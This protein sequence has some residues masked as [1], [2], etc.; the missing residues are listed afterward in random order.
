VRRTDPRQ[1]NHALD[2]AGRAAADIDGIAAAAHGRRALHHSHFEAIT[3]QPASERR[4][5]SVDAILLPLI[6]KAP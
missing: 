5:E 4:A 2:D 3:V 6:R 1:Q